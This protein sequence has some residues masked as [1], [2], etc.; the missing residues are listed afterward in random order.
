MGGRREVYDEVQAAGRL[1][2]LAAAWRWAAGSG[3]VPA[4]DAGPGLWSRAVVEAVDAEAV[5]AALPGVIGAGVAADRLTQALGTPLPPMRPRVAASAIGHLVR[6][7]LLVYLGGETEFPDV[8]P[9]QVAALA[10]RRDLPALLDEH[11]PLGPDQAAVRLGVRRRDFDEVVR[12]GFVAP[13]GTVEIDFKRQGGVTSV[14]LYS[15]RSIAL[16]DVVRPSVD[17]RAVRETRP[18]RRS[19]LAGLTPVTPDTDRVLLAGV[20]R[21]ASAGRSAGVGRA[22]VVNWRRRHPD[23]PAPTG[24]TDVHPEFDRADVVAWLLAHD[25]ITLPAGAGQASLLV[26]GT[27]GATG[28][29]RLDAPWLGLADDVEGTDRL[30][31]WVVDDADADALAA[32]AAGEFGATLTRLTAP[33]AGPLAVLGDVRVTDRFRSGSG[34]LRITLEWPARL[35]GTT[36]PTGTGGVVRHGVPQAR[37]GEECVC[38]RHDCGGLDPVLWCDEHGGEAPPVLDWHAGGG[39]R[40]AQ[41][42]HGRTASA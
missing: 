13:V 10:R 34:A 12:L 3:L 16:L 2:V 15:A 29:F 20:A 42:A 8:H 33:G 30:S 35:R 26:R 5:R 19:L 40:C 23:F 21:I 36:S 6:A 4:A 39:L 18:G 27:A 7:G 41:L 25:K 14:P 1:H 37:V 32:L 11:V 38:E 22:A 31:G 28:R 9:E 17:W 24:G